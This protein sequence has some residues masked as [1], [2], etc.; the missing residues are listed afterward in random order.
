MLWFNSSWQIRLEHFNQWDVIKLVEELL[1]PNNIFPLDANE[2]DKMLNF[3][4]VS[5]EHIWRYRNSIKPG[6]H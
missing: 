6:V 1:S 2:K 4:V 3:F 5:I